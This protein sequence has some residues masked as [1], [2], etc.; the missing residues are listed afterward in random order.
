MDIY[1]GKN[2]YNINNKNKDDIDYIEK[3]KKIYF[4]LNDIETDFKDVT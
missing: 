3:I 1:Y 4:K 2:K